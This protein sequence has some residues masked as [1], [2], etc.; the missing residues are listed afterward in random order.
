MVSVMMYVSNKD[1][2]DDVM[3]KMIIRI[4]NMSNDMINYKKFDNVCE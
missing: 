1:K 2:Y 3:S 4:I